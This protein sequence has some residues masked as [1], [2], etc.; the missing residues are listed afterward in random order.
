MC[1]HV[2]MRVK[3]LSEVRGSKSPGAEVTNCHEPSRHRYWEL[4]SGPLEEQQMLLTTEPPPQPSAVFLFVVVRDEF[5][6]LSVL[7][8]AFTVSGI[9]LSLA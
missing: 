5:K 8:P 9:S 1:L 7:N 2:G 3:L 4:N 6:T